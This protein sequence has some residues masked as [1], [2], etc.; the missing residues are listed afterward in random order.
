MGLRLEG[1]EEVLL[2]NPARACYEAGSLNDQLASGRAGR[3]PGVPEYRGVS[4]NRDVITVLFGLSRPHGN[5]AAGLTKGGSNLI[6][7]DEARALLREREARSHCSRAGL[8]ALSD[9]S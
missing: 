8:E 2:G 1:G 4:Q 9:E 6:E 3:G 7:L 5:I